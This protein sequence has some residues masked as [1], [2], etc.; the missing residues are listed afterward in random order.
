MEQSRF[1]NVS[2]FR[3]CVRGQS[4]GRPAGQRPS[5]L[6]ISTFPSPTPSMFFPALIQ[7]AG[8]DAKHGFKLSLEP[9]PSTV[10]YADLVSGNDKVCYCVAPAAIIR[11]VQQGA[12]IAL[13]WSAQDTNLLIIT[14]DP[15]IQT[16]KDLEGRTFGA[17]TGT[18]L[19]A[20]TAAFIQRAGADLS[21]INVHS[22][23]FQ[24]QATELLAGRADA[25][26]GLPSNFGQVEVAAP[27]RYRAFPLV[28][29]STWRRET[30]TPGIPLWGMGAWTDWLQVPSNLDLSRRLYAASLDGQAL[31]Q[32]DPERAADL[33]SG[34]TGIGA[35]GLLVEFKSFPEEFNVRPIKEYDGAI[36]ILAQGI[37]PAGKIIDRPANDAELSQI[38]SDFAP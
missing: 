19:W 28:N 33:V 18:G 10:A 21:K 37:L 13:L 38:V 32:K 22:S 25:I 2:S 15:T 4:H 24:A 27:G 9:K 17:D 31:I 30:G 1:G 7:R 16:A 12:P 6:H 36:K 29:I 35:A 8:L 5:E 23:S 26:L 3:H 14:A 34:A 11:L 20:L